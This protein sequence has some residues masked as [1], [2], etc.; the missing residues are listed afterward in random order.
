MHAAAWRPDAG[1]ADADVADATNA[2]TF[3]H[4]ASV[5]ATCIA[6]CVRCFAVTGG[7]HHPLLPSIASATT[8]AASA[9]YVTAATVASVLTASAVTAA[10]AAYV[11]AASTANNG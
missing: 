9:A 5:P 2:G 8:A 3:H 10:S 7:H 1:G 11:I 4:A 6:N